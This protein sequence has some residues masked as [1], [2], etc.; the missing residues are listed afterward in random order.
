MSPDGTGVRIISPTCTTSSSGLKQVS[1]ERGAMSPP[2]S[3]LTSNS[4][5]INERL[6]EIIQ[7]TDEAIR[8]DVSAKR[9]Y[10]LSL[11]TLVLLILIV[12]FGIVSVAH[13]ELTPKIWPSQ[14]SPFEIKRK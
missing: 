7:K 1:E 8:R 5:L 14:Q 4:Y 2:T 9:A 12:I 11:A 10:I 13:A 6:E 3:K